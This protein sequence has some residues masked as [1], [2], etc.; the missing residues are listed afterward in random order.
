M[1]MVVVVVCELE[2][3]ER[4]WRA[5]EVKSVG[6]HLQKRHLDGYVA[7]AVEVHA[8]GGTRRCEVPRPLEEL[9]GAQSPLQSRNKQP[10]RSDDQTDA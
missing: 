4:V 7:G 2:Q 5:P 8:E 1:M 9:S 10:V 3:D 6:R